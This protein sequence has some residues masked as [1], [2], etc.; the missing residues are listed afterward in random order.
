[1]RRRLLIFML[2]ALLCA[3]GVGVWKYRARLFRS[4][5][6]G[7][8]YEKYEHCQGMEVDFIRNM[9]IDDTTAV[10]VTV[11][12]TA[13]SV[14][15]ERLMADFD[16]PPATDYEAA[17]AASGRNVTR[18]VR[19]RGAVDGMAPVVAASLARQTIS[20]FHVSTEQQ[21]HAILYYNFNKSQKNIQQ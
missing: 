14:A 21:K 17:C 10:D 1:M 11:L 18:L 7:P 3:A 20:V 12:H 6:P 5:V 4:H 19:Y 2:L 16:L 9:R 13:D 15:W 8:L